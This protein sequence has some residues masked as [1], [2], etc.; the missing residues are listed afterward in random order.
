MKWHAHPTPPVSRPSSYLALVDG[1]VLLG[2]RLGVFLGVLLGVL[3]LLPPPLPRLRR[4]LPPVAV[5]SS[6]I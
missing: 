1:V 2:V 6:S 3:A 5:R 4:I